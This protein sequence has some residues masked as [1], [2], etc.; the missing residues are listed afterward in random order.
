MESAIKSQGVN[1][2]SINLL[3]LEKESVNM[4]ISESMCLPPSLSAYLS[5]VLH[6]KTAGS[7]LFLRSL[8]SDGM[9]RYNLTTRRYDYDTNKILMKEI[10]QEI[11]QYLASKMSL[12]PQS[13]RL[14][15]KLAS[16]LGFC[17]DGATFTK[18]RVSC[19]LAVKQG[20]FLPHI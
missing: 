20:I 8:L 12:L 19:L 18:A 5:S 9:I 17:F 2:F 11:V 3:P 6:R 10:P 15:L 16:C 13:Y 7:P 14:V 1:V 4:F